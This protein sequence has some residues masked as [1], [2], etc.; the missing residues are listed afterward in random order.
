MFLFVVWAGMTAKSS[1]HT[2]L[3][4]IPN[5]ALASHSSAVRLRSTTSFPLVLFSI[6][7]LVSD[8]WDGRN[9]KAVLQLWVLVPLYKTLPVATPHHLTSHLV[10][11]GHQTTVLCPLMD[12][13]QQHFMHGSTKNTLLLT[14]QHH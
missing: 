12:I 10:S 9:T 13:M 11:F 1:V 14:Q 6:S 7:E 2:G 4:L 5:M 8:A 3:G